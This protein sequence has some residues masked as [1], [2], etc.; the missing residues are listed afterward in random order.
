MTTD[1]GY[2]CDL[3]ALIDSAVL[4]GA[5][6]EGRAPRLAAVQF[7]AAR[8]IAAARD[9]HAATGV[10]TNG[11]RWSPAERAWLDEVAGVLGD[12]EI[13]AALGRSRM[14]VRIR[15]RRAGLPGPS[16]HPEYITGHQ[17]ALALG[18]DGHSVV[19]LIERGVLAAELAP[20][21]DRRVW[22]MRRAAFV[23]WAVRPENWPYFYRS[24]REP[25]RFGDAALRRLIA[26]RDEQWGDAWW[27]TGEVAAYHGVHDTDV[28]RY[29]Q[30]GRLPAVKWGNQMVRRSD[31]TRL[32]LK[33]YKGK[34]EGQ[35]E[36]H[37]TSRGDAFLVL[38]TAVGIPATQIAAMAGNISHTT[39][40]TRVMALHRR[41]YIAQLIRTYELPVLYRAGAP[42]AGLLSN[43]KPAPGGLLWADWRAVAHRFPRLARAWPRHEAGELR[44][45]REQRDRMLVNGVLRAAVA[46]HYGPAHPLMRQLLYR[47]RA[48]EEEAFGLW[49][50]WVAAGEVSAQTADRER[51]G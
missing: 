49:R 46:W 12:E 1:T 23:A 3:D 48:A 21:A 17:M 42:G 18:I 47:E 19:K 26:R 15:R 32:G 41:G 16:V 45:L 43:K 20:F 27:T 10:T 35:F 31:A 25:E 14:A 2:D 22:R 36:L 40:S 37:G 24:V 28:N 50:E 9:A 8:A 4:H 51:E 33:F 5:M 6:S 11:N 34:G 38:A 30:H 7:G 29:I 39:A 13:G 44:T